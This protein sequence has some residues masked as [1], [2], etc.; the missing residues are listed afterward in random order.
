MAEQTPTKTSPILVA[1]AWAIVIVPTA[2]GLTH[3]VQSAMKIF[4]H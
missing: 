3:T 1:V 2:W 4:G